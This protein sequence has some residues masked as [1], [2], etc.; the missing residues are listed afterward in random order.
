MH[1]NAISK[2]ETGHTLSQLSTGLQRVAYRVSLGSN[3]AL[4]RNHHSPIRSLSGRI[5]QRKDHQE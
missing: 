3:L 5:Q 1:R 2:E 4:V